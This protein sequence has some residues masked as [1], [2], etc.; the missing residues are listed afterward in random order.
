MLAV[1]TLPPT[2]RR[3]QR[4]CYQDPEGRSGVR[5]HGVDG[6]RF[7]TLHWKNVW[8]GEIVARH[9]SFPPKTPAVSPQQFAAI[10]GTPR[11]GAFL[12]KAL[13]VYAGWTQ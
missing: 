3:S 2:G 7:T 5:D 4:P 13:P 9:D 11:F 12:D 8:T 1:G 6:T 10:V